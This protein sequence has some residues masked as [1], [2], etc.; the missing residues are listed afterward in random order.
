MKFSMRPSL[1]PL[2]RF[3]AVFLSFALG[4]TLLSGCTA[5]TT[6]SEA[7]Q[8][9]SSTETAK[10]ELTDPGAA[11]IKMND[12]KSENYTKVLDETGLEAGSFE[13]DALPAG[14]KSLVFTAACN[15]KGGYRIYDASDDPFIL[16][17]PCSDYAA[18]SI[19]VENYKAP[20]GV[21]SSGDFR[22]VVFA[23]PDENPD[24]NN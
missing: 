11:T 2:R 23:S 7:K 13:L 22:V 17:A 20:L 8:T 18:I 14:T 21:W 12:P 24:E 6:K 5:E 3:S 4:L 15:G 9:E 19:P 1:D 10:P 16:L